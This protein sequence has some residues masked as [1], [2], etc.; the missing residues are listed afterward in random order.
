MRTGFLNC[1]LVIAA[2]PKHSQEEP[3]FYALGQTDA[4]RRLFV[5]FTIR[6]QLMRVI[7]AREMSRKERKVYEASEKE[8]SKVQE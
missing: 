8:T 7:S 6:G 3:R 4:A 1:P 5:V 2:D